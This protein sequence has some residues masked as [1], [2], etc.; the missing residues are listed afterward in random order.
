MCLM[1]DRAYEGGETRQL[2]LN[3]GFIPVVPPKANRVEPWVYD[4]VMHHRRN[5]IERL[6]QKKEIQAH[7]LNIREA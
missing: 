2:E 6:S 4:R 5:M 3:L 7:L 1:M